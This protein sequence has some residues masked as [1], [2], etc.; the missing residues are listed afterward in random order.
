MRGRLENRRVLLCVTGGI[1][2][3]KACDV[4]RLLQAEG[5]EV[6]VAMTAAAAEFIAPLTFE[7][8]SRL[9]VAVS[10]YPGH[11]VV[12]TRHVGWSEWAECTLVCPATLNCVGKAASGIADDFVTT[13][14]AAAR[15]AVVWAPAMDFGMAENAVYLR[16]VETL[17]ALGHRFVDPESGYL[18]SGASG[19]GRLARSGRILDAVR[20]ALHG[21]ATL[22][23]VRA[24]VTAG[25][26]AEA[27]DPV[28]FLTNP[29]TGKMGLAL[30]EEA[31][32]RGAR[33][34]LISGA[35]FGH[36]AD[37]IRLLPVRS[38]ADMSGAVDR[39]WPDHD[40]LVMAAAVG[41][42]RPVSVSSSKWKRTGPRRTI[43][44]EPTEDIVARAA[45]VKNG[46]IVAG[47]ALETEDGETNAFEKLTRKKLDLICLNPASEPDAGFGSDT[48]R[49]TLIDRNRGVR[50]LPLM[51]KWEAAEA[52]WDA[53]E[54][55]RNGGD[56]K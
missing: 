26:T 32:L 9:E 7:T 33:V 18:A 2:A 55:L 36:V 4:L 39:E 37:G 16:N 38:A 22:G 51:P 20:L 29:S 54:G 48:N 50:R 46:R 23:G 14:I 40:V 44:L 10:L 30:A 3:Y 8:L 41:D 47:F 34:S 25:P 52:V 43:E 49:L 6:R 15:T 11:R 12:T 13:A 42:Y 21:A 1:A 45:A 35:A 5:A 31:L 19:R 53:I 17:K 27:L 24:L 56:G 28:R